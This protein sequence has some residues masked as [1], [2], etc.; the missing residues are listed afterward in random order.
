MPKLKRAEQIRKEL[1]RLHKIFRQMVNNYFLRITFPLGCK[2]TIHSC[3]QERYISVDFIIKYMNAC[4]EDIVLRM[5]IRSEK[6]LEKF[7]DLRE[8]GNS[9]I[10]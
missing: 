4:S 8:I 6:D 9:M 2:V 5:K 3:C 10:F 1:I 7:K